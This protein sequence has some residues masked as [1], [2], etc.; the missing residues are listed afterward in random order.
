MLWGTPGKS[1][2]PGSTPGVF[3]VH[4][5]QNNKELTAICC[6]R[7]A[8]PLLFF[9][10]LLAKKGAMNDVRG[11]VREAVLEANVRGRSQIEIL[12]TPQTT[13]S[14]DSL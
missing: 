3:A 4:Y 8:G 6:P 5:T 14:V 11:G 13:P 2:N 10:V 12:L 1:E 9:S 7:S